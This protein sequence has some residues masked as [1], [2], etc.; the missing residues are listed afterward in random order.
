M[1]IYFVKIGS[2]LHCFIKYLIWI[3]L[4]RKSGPQILYWIIYETIKS[5]LYTACK[6]YPSIFAANVGQGLIFLR[7]HRKI[8]IFQFRRLTKCL[9]RRDSS[10][11]SLSFS[12]GTARLI[13]DLYTLFEVLYKNAVHFLCWNYRIRYSCLGLYFIYFMFDFY[14][15]VS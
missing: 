8:F 2:L 6:T 7:L 1:C 10:D 9:R 15:R 14:L 13:Y 5:V 11:Q 12:R 4:L 3:I